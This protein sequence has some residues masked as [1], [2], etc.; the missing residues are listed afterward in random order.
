LFLVGIDRF[1]AFMPVGCVIASH[2]ARFRSLR[3]CPST[4]RV[5]WGFRLVCRRDDGG[6]AGSWGG[7]GMRMVGTAVGYLD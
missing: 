4:I 7:C 5:R 3:P 6:S 1:S 2:L